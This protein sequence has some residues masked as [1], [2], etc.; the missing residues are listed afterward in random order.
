MRGFFHESGQAEPEQ[1]CD[2]RGGSIQPDL[3]FSAAP[4]IC[5][6]IIWFICSPIIEILF[7]ALLF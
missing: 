3:F 5:A 2:V 1:H 7:N 6:A 4:V